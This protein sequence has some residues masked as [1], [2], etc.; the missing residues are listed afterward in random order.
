MYIKS[1]KLTLS[2]IFDLNEKFQ[3]GFRTHSNPETTLVKMYGCISSQNTVQI[4]TFFCKG[5]LLKLLA[6]GSELNCRKKYHHPQLST[7]VSTPASWENRRAAPFTWNSSGWHVRPHAR[8]IQEG[9]CCLD[10]LTCFVRE[11]GLLLFPH[12]LDTPAVFRQSKTLCLAE[13]YGKDMISLLSLSTSHRVMGTTRR[14]KHPLKQSQSWEGWQKVAHDLEQ[15]SLPDVWISLVPK[16]AH[17]QDAHFSIPWKSCAKK[18]VANFS[19]DHFRLRINYTQKGRRIDR[20]SKKETIFAL[21]SW[22]ELLDWDIE[23]SKQKV[24]KWIW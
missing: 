11:E 22:S 1:F 3:S 5:I 7:K 23:S 2:G 4:L 21:I 9:V 13:I 10:P 19:L 15:I 20:L 24:V 8:G 12:C 14:P 17:D 18:G 6:L 16:G